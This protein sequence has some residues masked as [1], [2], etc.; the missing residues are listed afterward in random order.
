[1]CGRGTQDYTW[2]QL[3]NMFSMLGKSGPYSNLQPSYNVCPTDKVA[4][5]TNVDGERALHTMRWGLVPYS[6][7]DL[8]KFFRT[9]NARDDKL[10]NN[11]MW[12]SLLDRKRCVV[13]FNGFYEWRGEKPNKQA[14]YITR[15]DGEPLML[16]GLW[17]TNEKIDPEGMRSFTVITCPPN[18]VMSQVHSRMPVILDANAVDIWLA[19]GD[20]SD[21]Q[22][23]LI[24]P[25]PDEWLTAAPVN[26]KGVGNVRNKEKHLIDLI[27]EPIF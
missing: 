1:M 21:Q 3:H 22:R 9:F 20:W 24:K 4:L 27:G 14:Y 15:K 7:T 18:D 8:K 25:C 13:P 23:A 5:C 6:A 16:A 11:A 26:S 10:E 17:A 19:S 12:R 2:E